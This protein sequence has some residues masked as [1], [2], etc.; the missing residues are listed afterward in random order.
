MKSMWLAVAA[1]LLTS[2]CEERAAELSATPTIAEMRA[3]LDSGALSSEQLVQ[4]LI[5]RA[6]AGASLNAFITLDESAV[7]ER[8]RE[9]DAQKAAGGS[10]G[11][12]HGIPLVVKDNIHVAGV[13]NSAG[14]PGLRDFVPADNN[15]VVE[16]LISAGA[17]ILGKTNMHELA[18]GITSDNAAF[19]SVGNPHDPTLIP[20]GSSGG[21]GAAV[22]AGMA[23]AGLGSDTGGSVR[24]PAA[25]T[26]IA[27][28]RPSTGRY[29]VYG[30]TPISLTRDTIGYMAHSVADIALLDRVTAGGGGGDAPASIRLGVPRDYYY[31]GLD[32][33]TEALTNRTLDRLAAA[34]IELVDVEVPNLADLLAKSS[35]TIALYEVNRDLAAYLEDFQTGENIET[36]AA[37]IASPDVQ[38]VFAAILG[39]GAVPQAA[40]EAGLEAREALRGV[41]ARLFADEEIHALVFPTTPLPARPIEGSLQ[42]VELNGQQVPTF[43]TYIRNTDPASIAAL[44]SIS[45]PAGVTDNGLPVGIEL[46]GPEGSDAR[47]LAIAQRIEAIIGSAND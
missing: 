10:A 1:I 16:K 21:T 36:L 27:G 26:G 9:L 13:P 42:T 39:D 47:L 35:F 37:Q 46:D 38:G 25:L 11:A 30:V 20:G 45:L 41:Y 6:E 23:P 15:A 31:S 7:V 43:P 40:Y 44:P 17:I 14:T 29:A 3:L 5:R 22:S 8:A 32:R 18:F 12:L 2:A 4:Q 34:G 28:F 19:G 33:Q 24:I